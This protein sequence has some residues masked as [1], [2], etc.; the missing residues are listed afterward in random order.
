MDEKKTKL[1]NSDSA[2]NTKESEDTLN[3]ENTLAIKFGKLTP[4]TTAQ[5]IAILMIPESSKAACV[6]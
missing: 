6:Y 1:I 3:S 4:L 2:E 5:V